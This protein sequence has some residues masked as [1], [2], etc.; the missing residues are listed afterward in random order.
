M[1]NRGSSERIGDKGVRGLLVFAIL[2]LDS[3][4]LDPLNITP[5]IRLSDRQT[6]ALFPKSPVK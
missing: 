2:G 5:R 1:M 3:G 6:D 4:R